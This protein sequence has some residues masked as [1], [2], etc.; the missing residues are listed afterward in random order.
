VRCQDELI[1]TSSKARRVAVTLRNH[2]RHL[3]DN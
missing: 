3:G 2:K 1:L